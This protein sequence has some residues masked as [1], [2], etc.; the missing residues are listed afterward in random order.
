MSRDRLSSEN[1]IKVKRRRAGETA[2]NNR[3]RAKENKEKKGNKLV[4][5]LL[6][7]LAVLLVAAIALGAVLITKAK[8]LMS[9][10]EDAFKL[11]A[12]ENDKPTV[13]VDGNENESTYVANSGIYNILLLGIDSTEEREAKNYGYRSDVMMLCSIN[14]NDMSMHLT[15][16]PRDMWVTV[17]KSMDENGNVTSSVSQRINTAYSYGGG[18][19]R[20]GAKY[21]MKCMEDFLSMNGTFNVDIDYFISIDIDGLY[22]LADD[23][24]GVE[25]VMDRTVKGVGFEGQTVTIN[26]YNIDAYIRTRKG[27]GD[28]QG[29]VSR[30]QDYIMAVAKK[31]KSMG[32]TEAV[33]SMY[34]TITQYAKTNLTLDQCLAMAGFVREFELDNLTKYTVEGVGFTTSGG[35]KVMGCNE[36]AL[37][38]YMLEYF[39]TK[40]G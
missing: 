5:I 16:V 4:K 26:S 27:A 31:I 33:T 23:L 7:V 38:E 37:R 36:E 9:N 2:V 3:G 30:Q 28:D 8:D 25:V 20:D 6:I 24:G 10:P 35:A 22:K 13:V 40:Q 19:N 18:P 34:G 14:F 1:E 21:A 12:S 39:Y 17:P 32:T 15:S 29:R 11:D